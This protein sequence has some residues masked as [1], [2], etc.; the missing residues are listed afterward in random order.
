MISSDEFRERQRRVLDIVEEGGLDGVVAVGRAFYDRPGALAWL[1]NHFPPFPSTVFQPGVTGLGTGFLVLSERGATLLVDGP[2]YRDDLVVADE[3]VVRID[4]AAGL[5]EILRRHG[6][7]RVGLA[8]SDLMPAPIWERLQGSGIEWR[9]LDDQLWRLRRVKSP[10]EQDALRR[11]AEV[12][13]AGLKAALALVRPGVTEAEICA[14]GTA[15]A[16]E[17]G[18]DFVR[19]LR[20]HSGPWSGWPSRWPQATGRSLEAGDFVVLDIIGAVA[21]YGFDVLRTTVA[22]D[23][24]ERQYE[25][26]EAVAAATE[27]AIA[28]ATPG[29]TVQ[30][31][32]EAAHAVLTSRGF[33]EPAAFVGHGIGLETVE[34]PLLRADQHHELLAGEVL[35]IEPGLW[36]QDW[37]GASLEQEVIVGERPE[38][39]TPTPVPLVQG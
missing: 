10:A 39:I 32:V 26:L 35:C 30:E 18:A 6:A 38:I 2:H 31:L 13:D 3:V 33:E 25:I 15:A 14:A 29:T 19:Y 7:R 1:S 36:R 24:S 20:V 27:A 4:L 37:G 16:L 17:A 8:D 5:E 9:P 34:P 28:R 12:A 21:G 23:A 11:A 22:G